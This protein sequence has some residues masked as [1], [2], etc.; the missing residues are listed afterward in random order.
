MGN[1]APTSALLPEAVA[2]DCDAVAALG[3]ER[4]AR[5]S[6]T[7]RGSGVDPALADLEGA[8]L[9]ELRAHISKYRMT[10]KMLAE[11]IEKHQNIKSVSQTREENTPMEF[12]PKTPRFDPSDEKEFLRAC[13]DGHLHIVKALLGKGK[14]DVECH[15][16][17]GGTAAIFAAQGGHVDVIKYLRSMN[18]DLDARDYGASTPFLE[19][20]RAGRL[21][22]IEY[23]AGTGKCDISARDSQGWTAL[24]AAACY[25]YLDCVKALVQKGLKRDDTDVDGKT[26]LDWAIECERNVVVDFLTQ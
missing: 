13:S 23:L 24:H 26:P 18:A 21:A 22:A 1:G 6:A 8:D 3:E 19:A 17:S 9:E 10:A 16:L 25:G 14:V 7:P 15:S 5:A 20:A 4:A 2:A 12:D 11:R